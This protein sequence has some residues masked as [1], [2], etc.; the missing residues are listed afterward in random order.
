MASKNAVQIIEEKP[1]NI[2]AVVE[3]GTTEIRAIAV[4]RTKSPEGIISQ[5]I[6]AKEKLKTTQPGWKEGNVRRA[7]IKNITDTA[8]GLRTILKHLAFVIGTKYNE[9]KQF[10]HE[11]ITVEFKKVYVTLSGRGITT[12]QYTTSRRLNGGI[13]SESNIKEIESECI[14]SVNKTNKKVLN[15]IPIKYMVD[16]DECDTPIG[17]QCDVVEATYAIVVGDETCLDALNKVM[18]AAHVELA[19]WILAP[20]A[21]AEAYLG[22]G[23]GLG[24]VI[25]DFGAESTSIIIY[26]KNAMRFC[27]VLPGYASNAINQVLENR[28]II[29]QEAE[30]LKIRYA[31]CFL[32]DNASDVTISLTESKKEIS[33]K[34]I[35]DISAKVIDT[36]IRYVEACIEKSGLRVGSNLE[37]VSLVGKGCQL[38]GLS[39][40]LSFELGL[41][42]SRINLCDKYKKMLDLPEIPDSLKKPT[43]EMTKEEK[44]RF[45]NLTLEYKDIQYSYANVIGAV[46]IATESC[47][48]CKQLAL[49]PE[50]KKQTESLPGKLWG[51]VKTGLLEDPR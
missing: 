16:D 23:K 42:A 45:V 51:F 48:S 43:S 37:T 33:K 28:N 31:N 15:L 5:R 24:N 38:R 14:S 27:Y 22:D 17:C 50:E 49:P 25:I 36:I 19:G 40:K 8:Q 6:I 34:T 39:E 2:V 35:A 46:S 21:T 26:Y 30:T 13:I 1:M 47:F 11:K 7:Q 44:E 29:P 4:E 32:S 10:D 20:I 9:G 12:H 41:H 18:E 3:F